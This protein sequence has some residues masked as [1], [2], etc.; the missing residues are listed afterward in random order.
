MKN[1]SGKQRRLLWRI[2]R[3]IFPKTSSL[4]GGRIANAY[5]KV[6]ESEGF[7]QEFHSYYTTM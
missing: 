5:S 3:G 4:W 6:L 7:K 1:L 2:W